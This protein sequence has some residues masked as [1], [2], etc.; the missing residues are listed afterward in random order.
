[1]I[2]IYKHENTNFEANG[3]MTLTPTSSIFKMELN[4]I[5]EI[6]LEHPYDKLGR[7]KCIVADNVIAGPTPYSEKQLFRIY[8]TEKTLTGI[9]AYARHIF[10]DLID[11]ILLDLRPT[12]K[13]G[14]EALN[15]LLQG[16]GYT[17]HSNLVDLNTAYYIRKNI[18]EAIAGDDENSFVNRWGGERLYDNFDIYINSSVGSDN[19]VR[20]EFGYNLT[21][22][23]EKISLEDTVTRIIPLGF[24]GI[25]LEGEKPWVDSP[26]INKY[27]K[28]KTKVVE[29][30]DIKVNENADDEEGYDTLEEAQNATRKR[31]KELFEGGLDLPVCTYSVAMEDLSSTTAY[32]GYEVLENVSIGDTVHC[33]HIGLGIETKA[34]CVALEWI[35]LSKKYVSLTLG[36]VTKN[37]FDEQSDVAT[38]V[39]N[40]LNANG[41]VN[42][43]KLQGI[44][45]GLNT[46]FKAQK[47]IAQKQDVRAILFEDLD[48]DSPTFGATAIGTVGLEIAN[49]R[50]AT[51][52]DWEWNTFITAGL[53]YADWL[54]GKLMTVL[55]QNADGSFQIDLSKTGGAEYYNNGKIAM[56]MENNQLK[57]YDWK[58]GNY[59][60]S[61]GSTRNIKKDKPFIELWHEIMTGMS[62]GYRNSEGTISPYLRLD[63]YG[64]IDDNTSASIKAFEDLGLV[65]YKDIM[66]FG[67]D[68]SI[69]LGLLAL[70]KD[71]N[72][73][74]CCGKETDDRK[75][76]LG[77][78]KEDD[79]NSFVNWVVLSKDKV[80]FLKK[81]Y[82]TTTWAG[83]AGLF[84]LDN[85]LN[86]INNTL[87][88]F[89]NRLNNLESK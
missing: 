58:N 56:K 79:M 13:T 31:C 29:M 72:M 1:M 36:D 44:V 80:E 47:D 10:F 63:K 78:I 39:D 35:M 43:N 88:D 89:N 85:I 74:L 60:G 48:P 42:A 69:P 84:S 33:K 50:N 15:I 30:S 8:E 32:K 22:I 12:Q 75:L 21:E 19:G 73:H 81:I 14:E 53:V 40:I 34:R 57:F 52:T 17:G 7:W 76:F 20:A 64:I 77:A 83:N 18:V 4:G 11:S 65:N 61:L 59:I 62:F 28:I 70:G 45:N 55:I 38:R 67:N 25:M 9:K 46:K 37:F 41:T 68:Y 49:K 66:F 86:S 2:Q 71:N 6:E 27:A 3:D 87:D 82:I 54:V 5:C 24:D 23:E 16:T 26:N 51:N